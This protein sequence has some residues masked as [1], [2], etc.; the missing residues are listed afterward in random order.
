MSNIVVTPGKS[1][2]QVTV[3][4]QTTPID[5]AVGITGPV[6]PQGPAGPMGPQ[7]PTG[8]IDVLEMTWAEYNALPVKDPQTIYIITDAAVTILARL[9]AVEARLTALELQ[10]A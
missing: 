3:G 6:G 1:N 7:G 2:V 8:E 5:V 9:D 10:G 4:G